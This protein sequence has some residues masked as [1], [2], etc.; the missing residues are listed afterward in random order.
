MLKKNVRNLIDELTGDFSIESDTRLIIAALMTETLSKADPIR[1]SDT[2]LYRLCNNYDLLG[3]ADL[4]EK[5]FVKNKN[6]SD[7]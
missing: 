7:G 6:F 3:D 2:Y 5:K 1:D 4:L